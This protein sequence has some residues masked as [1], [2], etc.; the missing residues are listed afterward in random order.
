M[1]PSLDLEPPPNFSFL[2]WVCLVPATAVTQLWWIFLLW[3][4]VWLANNRK[5]D[6]KLGRNN[7]NCFDSLTNERYWWWTYDNTFHYV[8]L[9]NWWQESYFGICT[10]IFKNWLQHY[11]NFVQLNLLMCGINRVI[12][13]L[14]YY[15][16]TVTVW[17]TTCLSLEQSPSWKANRYF[18]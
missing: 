10:L 15:A 1:C 6:T 13:S 4:C 16:Q 12:T 11:S 14:A 7:S 8:W 9:F 17:C 2:S 18:S 3:Y 5:V